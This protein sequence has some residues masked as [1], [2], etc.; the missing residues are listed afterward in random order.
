MTVE[1][2]KYTNNSPLRSPVKEGYSHL[3]VQN[4]HPIQAQ[5]W[6]R[7]PTNQSTWDPLH[8]AI[9][10]HS[11]SLLTEHSPSSPVCSSPH[12]SRSTTHFVPANPICKALEEQG[13]WEPGLCRTDTLL[14]LLLLLASEIQKAAKLAWQELQFQ[15]HLDKATYLTQAAM[16][17]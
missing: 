9:D 16:L 2:S 1:M 12:M 7:A 3:R 11:P 4:C 6:H 5:T 14:S 17:S 8:S 10:S 15:G 13:G